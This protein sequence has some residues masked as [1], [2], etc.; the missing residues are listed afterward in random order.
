MSPVP[1]LRPREVV[2]AFEK[3]GWQVARELPL[4]DVGVTPVRRPA[5]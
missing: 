2:G 5:G 1:I 4:R 3:L